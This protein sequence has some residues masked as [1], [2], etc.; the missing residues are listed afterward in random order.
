MTWVSYTSHGRINFN[1]H[2][3]SGGLINKVSASQPR[4]RDSNPIRVTTMI[5]HKTP[6]L[7]GSRKRTRG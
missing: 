6:V 3:G 1:Q 2:K 5:P 7:I 4:D